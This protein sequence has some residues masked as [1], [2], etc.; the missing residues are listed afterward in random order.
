MHGPLVRESRDEKG[1]PCSH[2]VAG[3]LEDLRGL[4][5]GTWFP[6][7]KSIWSSRFVILSTGLAMLMFALMISN[8]APRTK[9]RT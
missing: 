3:Q 4:R 6:I 5:V 8:G 1:G 2:C 9:I 7:V